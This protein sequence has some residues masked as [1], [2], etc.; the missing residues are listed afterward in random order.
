MSKLKGKVAIVTGASKGSACSIALHLA[1]EAP[2][3]SSTTRPNKAGADRVV[4][5]IVG[6][7]GK[8]VAVQA[9]S[10]R[11]SRHQRL[12]AEAKKA[13]G[14]PDSSLKMPHL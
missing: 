2:R 13:F 9:T 7:R 4:A 8:A 10:P 6:K 1:E 11:L 5:E 14:S 12:F 3:W